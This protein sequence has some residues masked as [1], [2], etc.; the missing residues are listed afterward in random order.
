MLIGYLTLSHLISL[1]KSQFSHL[2]SWGNKNYFM[3]LNKTTYVKGLI[4][5]QS[6]CFAIK[7]I[8]IF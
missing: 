7:G 3:G 6:S 5:S 4:H 2:E 8:F 1:S